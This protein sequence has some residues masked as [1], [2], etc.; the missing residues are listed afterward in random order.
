MRPLPRVGDVISISRVAPDQYDAPAGHSVASGPGGTESPADAVRRIAASAAQEDGAAPLD[1]A[2][3]LSLRHRGLSGKSLWLAH[4]DA[5]GA[6]TGFALVEDAGDHV[7][8]HL[9]VEPASRRAGVGGALARSVLDATS[10]RRVTAWSHGNHPGA[11]RLA[12]TLGLERVRD[13]WVM[14][15]PL[16]ADAP[17]PPVEPAGGT[18][19]RAF[20]PGRDEEAFLAVNAE[21]FIGHPEQGRMTRADLEE[22]MAEPW[23]DPAGFFLAEPADAPSGAEDSVESPALLGFHWTKVHDGRVGEVY[24]VG[25]S[26]AAQGRGLGRMLTLTGLHHLADQGLTEVILYVE[27]DNAAAVAV[28]SGL[29]FTHAEVD[30]H[31]MYERPATEPRAAG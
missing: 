28:Y 15:R 26:P 12:H 30:T 19:V 14:R 23:F 17:L 7:A 21:A 3:L 20:V 22:R 6:V 4:D 31:V 8:L 11:A 27:A 1:E 18:V 2:T 10:G 25:I 24:V 29:G 5:D 16:S 13:L 9:V